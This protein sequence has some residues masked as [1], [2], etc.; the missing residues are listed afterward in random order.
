MAGQTRCPLSLFSLLP[1]LSNPYSELFF[2]LRRVS[3]LSFLPSV[4]I[5]IQAPILVSNYRPLL[6]DTVYIA[7]FDVQPIS[8]TLK[9]GQHTHTCVHTHTHTHLTYRERRRERGQ[10]R[11]GGRFQSTPKS[12]VFPLIFFFQ[13]LVR[14]HF[15]ETSRS[16]SQENR[17]PAPQKS[18]LKKKKQQKRKRT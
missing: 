10:A 6:F 13:R 16:A 8:R 3:V 2:L 5:C 18:P 7:L 15:Q 1:Y 9:H 14:S 12:F 11:S 17:V 4:C